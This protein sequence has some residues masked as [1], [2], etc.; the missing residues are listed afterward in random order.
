MCARACK[1]IARGDAPKRP[2]PVR[3]IEMLS[4]L[5]HELHERN[6]RAPEQKRS[7]AAYRLKQKE[8]RE[9]SPVRTSGSPR[10][11]PCEEG[12]FSLAAAAS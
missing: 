8:I 5:D 4:K 7:L 12:K 2:K 11:V 10:G 1:R 6:D 9:G 3:Q